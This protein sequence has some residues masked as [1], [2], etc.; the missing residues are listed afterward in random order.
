ML[1]RLFSLKRS[2]CLALYSELIILTIIY[3]I[4]YHIEVLQI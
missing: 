3:Q 1:F 4:A 2:L